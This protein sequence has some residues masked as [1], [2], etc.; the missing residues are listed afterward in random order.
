M[1]PNPDTRMAPADFVVV[2][3]SHKTT[4]TSLRD[5]LFV[6]LA[7]EPT[8]LSAL[9]NGGF[10]QAVIVSTCDR[11]EFL[12]YA[13]DPDAAHRT[14]RAL[15]EMRLGWES[16]EPHAVYALRGRDAARHVFAIASSLES[17][18]VGEAEILGQLKDIHARAR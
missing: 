4:S 2:G 5:R 1:A 8:V 11:V 16:F 18:I 3:A 13:A 6:A 10:Y 12:G 14:A 7:D 17:A 9:R 15:L